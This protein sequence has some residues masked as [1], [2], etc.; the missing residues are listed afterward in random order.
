MSKILFTSGG[1]QEKFNP[2]EN[3]TSTHKVDKSSPFKYAGAIL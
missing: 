2:K 1:T 3:Q